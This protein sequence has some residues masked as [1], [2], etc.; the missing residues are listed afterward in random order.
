MQVLLVDRELFESS[1]VVQS[2]GC[3]IIDVDAG[4]ADGRFL[5]LES[6]LMLSVHIWPLP[7][8]RKFTITVFHRS[9]PGSQLRKA[10]PMLSSMMTSSQFLNRL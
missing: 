10:T 8:C 3:I 9:R 2:W 7:L 4:F 5:G 6:T 1:R